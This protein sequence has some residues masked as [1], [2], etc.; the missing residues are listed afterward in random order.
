LSGNP[1]GLKPRLDARL[2]T[3]GMTE[4]LKYFPFYC[5]T[6]NDRFLGLR[7]CI[8]LPITICAATV[9]KR[10][11]QSKVSM[12]SFYKNSV[13]LKSACRT[14]FE[15]R[16]SILLNFFFILSINGR[17][18]MKLLRGAQDSVDAPARICRNTGTPE[19]PEH[20]EPCRA[21]NDKNN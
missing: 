3:S 11:Y 20:I 13:S 12:I 19:D 14:I 4:K 21:S 6:V 1:E 17:N 9:K 15:N 8:I 18:H 5:E 10:D 7:S 16:A 2:R